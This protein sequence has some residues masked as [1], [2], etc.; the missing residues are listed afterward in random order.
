MKD[1]KKTVKVGSSMYVVLPKEFVSQEEPL[2]VEYDEANQQVH[3][4]KLAIDEQL[5]EELSQKL[6]RINEKI[7]KHKTKEDTVQNPEPAV[8][9]PA[10]DAPTQ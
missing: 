10:Q 6:T 5:D 2:I 3:I 7:I 1:I 9:T 4:R 8:E